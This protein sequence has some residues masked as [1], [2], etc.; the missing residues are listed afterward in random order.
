[1]NPH[2][3]PPS[4]RDGDDA[5]ALFAVNACLPDDSYRSGLSGGPPCQATR[6]R[7]QR[8]PIG[9]LPALTRKGA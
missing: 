4:I 7:Y 9:V 3:L 6:R 8:H 5:S 1:M 2:L